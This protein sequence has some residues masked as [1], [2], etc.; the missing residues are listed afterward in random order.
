MQPKPVLSGRFQNP[1]TH[2]HLFETVWK[3]QLEDSPKKILS[4]ASYH[5]ISDNFD[6]H[7]K[8]SKNEFKSCDNDEW[9]WNQLK[10]VI[11]SFCF[12][13]FVYLVFEMYERL[14]V[15]V[16]LMSHGDICVCVPS[17][18]EKWSRLENHRC[19]LPFHVEAHRAEWVSLFDPT[20]VRPAE[21]ALDYPVGHFDRQGQ[22]NIIYYDLSF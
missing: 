9:E 8:H 2:R 15:K 6:L 19:L 10:Y 21:V 20:R 4:S 13:T 5:I 1:L 11:I 14:Q 12:K 7:T 16:S 3:E 18:C 17:R 22:V